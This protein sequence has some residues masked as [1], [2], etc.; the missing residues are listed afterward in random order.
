M[1]GVGR[2]DL[3]L[4]AKSPHS[5]A[6]CTPAGTPGTAAFLPRTTPGLGQPLSE[7]LLSL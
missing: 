4:R 1:S 3:W 6:L 2:S 5:P 7:P